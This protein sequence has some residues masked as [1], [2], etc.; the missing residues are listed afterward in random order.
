[1]IIDSDPDPALPDETSV[2]RKIRLFSQGCRPFGSQRR[3]FDFGRPFE[4]WLERLYLAVA[5]QE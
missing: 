1:M 5:A 3:L 4:S 2:T